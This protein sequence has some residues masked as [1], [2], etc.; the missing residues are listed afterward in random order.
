MAATETP[1]TVGA[2]EE[3]VVVAEMAG[4]MEEECTALL[5][6]QEEVEEE[7]EASIRAAV[8]VEEVEASDLTWVRTLPSSTWCEELPSAL[9][10]ACWR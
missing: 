9:T 6:E 8:E 4:A 7:G 10:P 3:A 2:E 5:A 1:I